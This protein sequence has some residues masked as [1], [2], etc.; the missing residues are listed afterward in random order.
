MHGSP[1]ND[2]DTA[3]R[4]KVSVVNVSDRA[5]FPATLRYGSN[6]VSSRHK[7]RPAICAALFSAASRDPSFP[8]CGS[9]SPASAW[10]RSPCRSSSLGDHLRQRLHELFLCVTNVL[11]LVHEQVVHC[12]DV[13]G[14]QSHR[15]DPHDWEQTGLRR[16]VADDRCSCETANRPWNGGCFEPIWSRTRSALGTDAATASIVFSR[17]VNRI[18]RWI[19]ERRMTRCRGI[20]PSCQ[21]LP[22][23]AF[24]SYGFFAYEL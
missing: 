22:N 20:T 24:L 19:Y 17:R 13:F 8:R 1:L 2:R 9:E 11:K 5:P 14:K 3:P 10:D 23:E 16:L 7:K 21:G 4:R 6:Y 12:F 15:L 18:S